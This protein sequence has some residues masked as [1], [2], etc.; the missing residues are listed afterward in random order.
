MRSPLNRGG[1]IMVKIVSFT[2]ATPKSELYEEEELR[3]EW[4]S[5]D[6]VPA[7]THLVKR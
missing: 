1:L 2:V 3:E 4:Y 7:T 5:P 6:Q